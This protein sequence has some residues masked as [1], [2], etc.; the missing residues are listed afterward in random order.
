[1]NEEEWLTCPDPEAMLRFLHRNRAS[2]RKFRL[3][4]VACVRRVW[5]LLP[6]DRERGVVDVAELLAD[7]RALVQDLWLARCRVNCAPLRALFS[8]A[9]NAAVEVSMS[10]AIAL[11]SGAGGA[12]S[13]G[14]RAAQAGL[15]RELFG[16]PV[17]PA[18]IEPDWLAWNQE[19]VREMAQGIYEDRTFQRLPI[20]ADAL[21]DAGC[22][23][24]GILEHLRGPD[25]HV[26]GCWA[27]DLILNKG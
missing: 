13:L 1:V 4:A 14:E 26:R 8:L 20:L 15:L 21:E 7:G 10:A 17:R 6:S 23:E 2:D 18:T 19:F 12:A 11:R 9:Y 25:R 16:N 27:V 3:F 5:H 22:G 24:R